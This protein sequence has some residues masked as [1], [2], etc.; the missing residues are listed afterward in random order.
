M[1]QEV[2]IL[3]MEGLVAVCAFLS[4]WM[5]LWMQRKFSNGTE[6]IRAETVASTT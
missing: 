2:G 5:V 3:P 4:L 6:D 1:G